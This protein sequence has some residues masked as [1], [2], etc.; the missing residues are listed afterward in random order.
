MILA[1]LLENCLLSVDPLFKIYFIDYKVCR[2]RLSLFMFIIKIYL[3]N[4]AYSGYEVF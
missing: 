2:Y 4:F 3:P 1:R